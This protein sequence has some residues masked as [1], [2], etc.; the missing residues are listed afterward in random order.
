MK[1]QLVIRSAL[2]GLLAVSAAGGV[3]AGDDM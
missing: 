2:A 3:L 1:H